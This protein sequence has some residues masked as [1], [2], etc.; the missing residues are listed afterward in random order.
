MFSKKKKIKNHSYPTVNCS[1][2]NTL[3]TWIRQGNISKTIG[4]VKRFLLWLTLSVFD[5]RCFWFADFLY[6]VHTVYL[7]SHREAI[8]LR[9]T[10]SG[11]LTAPSVLVTLK[12]RVRAARTKPTCMRVVGQTNAVNVCGRPLMT[13]RSRTYSSQNYLFTEVW[14]ERSDR[15]KGGQEERE[16][17]N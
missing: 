13:S 2:T 16:R 9:W 1:Y 12:R 5:L 17:V 11:G 15:K 14:R 7:K 8:L 3:D 10:G 4:E 6:T